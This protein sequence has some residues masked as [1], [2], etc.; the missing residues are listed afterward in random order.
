MQLRFG[1]FGLNMFDPEAV[2]LQ[3]LLH[4]P[5]FVA[6]IP[7]LSEA[8]A[9]T[10]VKTVVVLCVVTPKQQSAG[11]MSVFARIV[12][13]RFAGPLGASTAMRTRAS[14]VKD[15]KWSRKTKLGTVVLQSIA[16]C[17]NAFITTVAKVVGTVSLKTLEM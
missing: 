5:S 3:P 6:L 8:W 1:R 4:L 13:W 16:P 17:K 10:I 14:H 12:W 15:A 11:A 7:F 9:F 2:L